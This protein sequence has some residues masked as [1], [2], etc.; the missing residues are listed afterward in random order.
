MTETAK[1]PH[2]P[3]IQLVGII[4][5]AHSKILHPNVKSIGQSSIE[6]LPIEPETYSEECGTKL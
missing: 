6:E 3:R 5:H 4:E 1:I 2:S